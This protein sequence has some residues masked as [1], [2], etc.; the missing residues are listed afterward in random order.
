MAI[1]KVQVPVT[2]TKQLC[3]LSGSGRENWLEMALD[4]RISRGSQAGEWGTEDQSEY[5][6]FLN[7]TINILGIIPLQYP[8]VIDRCSESWTDIF[9][10]S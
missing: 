9:F 2:L 7:L 10:I 4:L 8:A 3:Q 6:W 5:F 1:D